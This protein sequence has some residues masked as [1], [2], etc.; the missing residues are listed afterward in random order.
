MI[1]DSIMIRAGEGFTQN[2]GMCSVFVDE[3]A[4][5]AESNNTKIAENQI[6]IS[7]D[8]AKYT[9]QNTGTFTAEYKLF[10]LIDLKEVEINVVDNQ[11]VIPGGYPVGIY[12]ETN[13]VMII[14]TGSV[15][16]MDNN[17]YTPA[18]NIV[19]SGDY[20]VSINQESVNSKSELIDKINKY[21]ALSLIHI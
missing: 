21:G 9:F 20:V 7:D 10:G 19:K 12:V 14:G 1:P 4:V 13:G 5:M 16:G 6:N 15:I 8:L 3:K 2:I 11:T 17:E 18:E